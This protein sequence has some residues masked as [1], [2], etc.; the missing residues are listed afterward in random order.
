MW[1]KIAVAVILLMNI[2]ILTFCY[3]RY[4]RG[5]TIPQSLLDAWKNDLLV[6]TDLPG[7]PDPRYLKRDK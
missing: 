2:G 3:L 6:R 7:K 5:G 1:W 4:K